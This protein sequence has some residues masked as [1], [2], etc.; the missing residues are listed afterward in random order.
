MLDYAAHATSTWNVDEIRR[1]F[2]ESSD[3]ADEAM[4][5]LLDSGDEPDA[6]GFWERVRVN[7]DAKRVRLLFVADEIPER[8][9]RVVAFLNEQMPNI[10]VWLSKSNASA[11]RRVARC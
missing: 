2:E 4:S 11:A 8:L 7:L 1:S 5:R 3:N 9:E 10:E 6:E